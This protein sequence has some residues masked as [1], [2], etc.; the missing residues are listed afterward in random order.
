MSEIDWAAIRADYETGIPLRRLAEKYGIPKSV[1]GRQKF[2]EQW[3]RPQKSGTP[4]KTQ[5]II[6]PDLNAALRAATAFRL[7]FDEFKTWEE[8]AQLAGYASRGA[9][10]NAVKREAG[11]HITHDLTEI[12][13][14]ELYRLNRLQARCYT[15]AMDETNEDWTWAIDRFAVL[16]KRKSELMGLDK[17]VDDAANANLL[18]IREVPAGLFP[19][20]VEGT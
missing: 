8:V 4:T 15:A 6:H 16:S 13:E 19:S 2:K 17:P 12:R 5:E 9:A 1:L 20:V 14:E 7:R 18:V 11:R 10:R 3:D